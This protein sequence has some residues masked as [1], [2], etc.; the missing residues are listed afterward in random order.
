[1]ETII[2]RPSTLLKAMARQALFGKYKTVV[3]V[4][5]AMVLAV[6]F[7]LQLLQ[8]IL[9]L[10]S[11]AGSAIYLAA[12]T[13]ISLLAAAFILGQNRIY[14]N[15]ARG[16]EIRFS[17]MWY[18]FQNNADT[19]IL[20]KLIIT[21][22]TTA[23]AIPFI[24][25]LC[26]VYATKNYYLAPLAGITCSFYLIA[27]AYIQLT[28]SQVFYLML[29]FPEETAG[30]LLARSKQ[31]MKGNRL[32]LFYLQVSFVGLLILGTISFNIG[33]FW[34]MPYMNMTLAGFYEDIRRQQIIFPDE[35]IS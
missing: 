1:M 28:Y 20:A 26:I 19:A 16:H 25:S 23:A 11:S 4:Y 24:V 32:R 34:V 31:L 3:P 35:I 15:I 29:D 18:G 10:K 2:K 14:L 30:E 13:I 7:P 33:L 9:N 5:I 8:R 22:K 17:Q 21:L 6:G 12:Y 27:A